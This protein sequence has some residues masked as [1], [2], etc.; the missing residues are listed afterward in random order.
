MASTYHHHAR[1]THQSGSR[2]TR[3]VDVRRLFEILWMTTRRPPSGRYVTT[4]L[5]CVVI[6]SLDP[7][8]LAQFWSEVTGWPIV[9]RSP[10]RLPSNRSATPTMASRWCSCQFRC[11]RPRRTG[12]ISMSSPRLCRSR[13][14]SSTG[15][16]RSGV[17]RVDV[18]SGPCPGLCSPIR[19][20]TSCAFSN[21]AR[22]YRDTGPIAA[23]VMDAIAPTML[24]TFWSAATG[25]PVTRGGPHFAAMRSG[26]GRGPIWSCFA[27]WIPRSSR[28]GCIS[29]WHRWRVTTKPVRS[30]GCAHWAPPSPMSAGMCPGSY[31]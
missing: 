16:T 17:L 13:S 29:T 15:C 28:T 5:D 8:A 12:S 14:R 9:M 21:P 24:A 4:R 1:P 22:S 10:T 31:R 2:S 20:A 7:V 19:K 23:V 27:P 6:D 30:S 3:T 18:A 11:R 25:W 26:T